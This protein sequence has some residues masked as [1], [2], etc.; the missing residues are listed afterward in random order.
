[1]S[2]L[3]RLRPRE[4]EPRHA[5][6]LDHEN[7]DDVYKTPLDTADCIYWFVKDDFVLVVPDPDPPSESPPAEIASVESSPRSTAGDSD[8]TNSESDASSEEGPGGESY[9]VARFRVDS[10]VD[11][12]GASY[13]MSLSVD[14]GIEGHFP[15]RSSIDGANL[16]TFP[17][18]ES[19][20]ASSS[21]VTSR[22][23]QAADTTQ[24][25]NLTYAV[26]SSNATE[27]IQVRG[28]IRLD[29]SS[30]ASRV[31][32]APSDVAVM[33]TEPLQGEASK[34]SEAEGAGRPQTV[35]CQT[36]PESPSEGV[37]SPTAHLAQ[38]STEATV[39]GVQSLS[40]TGEAEVR[41]STEDVLEPTVSS[42]EHRTEGGSQQQ[43]SQSP[44]PS[45][46]RP[47]RTLPPGAAE[48]MKDTQD[49]RYGDNGNVRIGRWSIQDASAP[50]EFPSWCWNRNA[51]S[52]TFIELPRI[53]A[54]RV[55]SNIV[56][57]QWDGNFGLAIPGLDVSWA[58]LQTFYDV[59]QHNDN[60]RVDKPWIM[61]I[62]LLWPQDQS[63]SSEKGKGRASDDRVF[64]Y[65]GDGEPCAMISSVDHDAEPV[66]PQ[67]GP[68]IPVWPR[69]P[70]N[71]IYTCWQLRLLSMTLL[72]PLRDDPD[73]TDDSHWEA[74]AIEMPTNINSGYAGVEI[75]LDTCSS[76]SYFPSEVIDNIVH[77]WLKDAR[78]LQQSTRDSPKVIYVQQPEDYENFDIVFK[79][80][81][82][83][84]EVVNFRCGARDFLISPYNVDGRGYFCPFAELQAINHMIVPYEACTLGTNF[85]WSA[86]TRLVAPLHDG[87]KG[88][89]DLSR[90]ERP[91]VQLAPQRIVLD[92]R[93]VAGPRDIKIYEEH[94][95]WFQPGRHEPMHMAH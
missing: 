36:S 74:I 31:A 77:L 87:T 27:H 50:F 90:A 48:D 52:A 9:D 88:G 10:H 53:L 49:V 72:K 91:Y 56:E 40:G 15:S 1:M 23:L 30:G 8:S 43:L 7:V 83:D 75:V 84:H 68:R 20:R 73:Y 63:H 12:G 79:F 65:F 86:M 22:V 44:A 6:L 55:N 4:D 5:G 37:S 67:W 14:A 80:L 24:S 17:M 57:Q 92:G 28:H 2:S 34:N 82:S 11:I 85:F 81:G 21:G 33:I 42:S 59:L 29:P 70:A 13:E 78:T 38:E 94:P 89:W 54:H 16:G 32:V 93:K 39:T 69:S 3:Q 62:R 19:A 64:V 51:E 95:P 71:D 25:L 26:L 41:A 46:M 60:V 76:H 47:L 35:E 66:A 58:I 45:T 18:G 61:T